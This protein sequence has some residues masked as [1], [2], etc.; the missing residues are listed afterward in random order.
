MRHLSVGEL[1]AVFVE[2]HDG[3][4]GHVVAI[5]HAPDWY[6]DDVV[7]LL[8]EVGGEAGPFVADDEGRAA[9]ELVVVQA[10]G[11]GRL[12]ESDE[13]IAIGAQFVENWREGAMGFDADCVGAFASDV[14]VELGRAGADDAVDAHA[15]GGPGDPREIDVAPHWRAGDQ[16]LARLGEGSRGFVALVFEVGHVFMLSCRESASQATRPTVYCGVG[17]NSRA[18]L[19]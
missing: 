15:A 14:A 4:G 12:L 10:A 5:R 2:G 17:D 18:P 7:E 1:S 6:L 3:G 9:L 8:E 16:Q 13:A 11:V 19:K